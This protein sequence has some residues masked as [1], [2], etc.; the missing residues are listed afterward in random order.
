[1]KK[2]VLL[3]F[4]ALAIT[5]NAQPVLSSQWA[6]PLNG[7]EIPATAATTIAVTSLGNVYSTGV[8][9]EE[10]SFAG[11]VLEPITDSSY[12]LKYG[13]NGNEEWGVV[14]SG[15]IA[16]TSATVDEAGNL[17][18][19]GQFADEVEF[20]STS[21]SSVIKEG[22]SKE[23]GFYAEKCAAFIAK[24]NASGELQ[25][26]VDFVPHTTP[27][28]VTADFEPE[29]SDIYFRISK[30]EVAN[31]RV[32]ASAL[33]TC[34]TVAAG[35]TFKGGLYDMEGWGMIFTTVAAG[36]VFSLDAANLNNGKDI[37]TFG[38]IQYGDTQK[39][40]A[41][42]SSMFALSDANVYVA[43]T[44]IQDCKLT[45]GQYSKDY[46][47][48]EAR[49][50]RVEG[51]E[52]PQDPNDPNSDII[53]DWKNYPAEVGFVLAAVDAS[54]NMVSIHDY[55]GSTSAASC[56]NYTGGLESAGEYLHMLSTY[57]N[58]CPF[59][60]AVKAKE[61][62]NGIAACKIA[63]SDYA[64]SNVAT[65]NSDSATP[66]YY[67]ISNMAVAD[68][69][70]YGAVAINTTSDGLTARNVY[71]TEN[72]AFAN[73]ASVIDAPVAV[74]VNGDRIAF[75]SINGK[76]LT[77]QSYLNTNSAIDNVISEN[78]VKVYPNPVVD[79]LNFSMPVDVTIYSVLGVEMK[80]ADNVS[81]ISVSELPA[82]QYIVK[83]NG[84]AIHVLKK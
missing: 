59:D 64:V 29:G 19:A 74:D 75:N 33:Y 78:I 83:A 54:G 22:A 27:D 46:N 41:A 2:S 16:V 6:K 49:L 65:R 7:A 25:S 69:V 37:A 48:K 15:S 67:T 80:H 30:I 82:G 45:I 24:Y 38:Q 77:V 55:M 1:M 9:T 73:I 5:A 57:E 70:I 60:N 43:F 42:V 26:V 21:G 12:I 47:F 10:F 58:E 23:G 34:E 39:G 51:S 14:L 8:F 61:N 81:S 79:V 3:V 63:K 84:N 72:S 31:G 76:A 18:V 52:H 17:Y 4:S 62:Y 13:T 20:G 53:Y 68:D 66:S 40:S 35:L 71:Q 11:E 44:G 36:S 50:E 28:L 32:Y 56:L